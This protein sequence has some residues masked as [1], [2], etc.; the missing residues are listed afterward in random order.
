MAAQRLP[1]FLG[2]PREMTSQ[3]G[4]G[5]IEEGA[6]FRHREPALWRNHMHRQRCGLVAGEHDFELAVLHLL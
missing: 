1:E 3:P 6:D 5:K 2:Q 4:H